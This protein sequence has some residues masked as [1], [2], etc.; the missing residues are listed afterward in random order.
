MS[1]TYGPNSD[2]VSRASEAEP[3]QRRRKDSK[4]E[5]LT[6]LDPGTSYSIRPKKLEGFLAKRRKWPL[7]GW[8]K[9]WLAPRIDHK[10]FN[11]QRHLLDNL[12]MLKS[13]L[14]Q[15]CVGTSTSE[16]LEDILGQEP[17]ISQVP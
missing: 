14:V 10:S 8:H 1:A 15:V 9:R 12:K 5:I 6:S 4:W 2:N 11:K 13:C 7:K 17:E 3:K 16:R